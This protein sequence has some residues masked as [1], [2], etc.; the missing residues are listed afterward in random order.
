MDSSAVIVGRYI[1]YLL[2]A[3]NMST[4][5]P[6]QTVGFSYTGF[7]AAKVLGVFFGAD[8]PFVLTIGSVLEGS[9][10]AGISSATRCV[11]DSR[12]FIIAYSARTTVKTKKSMKLEQCVTC[13]RDADEL[14]K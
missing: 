6:G 1:Y 13:L 11:Q 4:P 12:W 14:N 10:Y 7:H 2:D 8:P 5:R 3:C 9:L